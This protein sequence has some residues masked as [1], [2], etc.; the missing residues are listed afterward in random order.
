M[1]EEAR[2]PEELTDEELAAAN[3]EPLPEREQMSVIR[4][5][6]MP[7]PIEFQ[8]LPPESA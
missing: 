1:S 2:T 5:P 4:G 6:H 3:A 8:P 7:P